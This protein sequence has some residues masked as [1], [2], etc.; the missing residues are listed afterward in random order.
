MPSRWVKLAMPRV[1]ELMHVERVAYTIPRSHGGSAAR[2]LS[3]W[4]TENNGI[5]T[6][7]WPVIL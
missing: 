4:E 2:R 5:L 7:L 3:N 1:W 6:G